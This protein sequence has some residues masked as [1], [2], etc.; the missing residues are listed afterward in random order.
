MEYYR[1]TTLLVRAKLLL[2]KKR[3]QEQLLLKTD[4]QLENLE[5]LTHDIEFAQVEVQ[6]VEGLKR[7]MKP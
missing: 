4:A 6:V 5:K 2:K 1:Q 3:Y 7:E